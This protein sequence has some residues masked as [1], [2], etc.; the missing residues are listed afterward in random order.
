MLF[1]EERK[2]TGWNTSVL[3]TRYC[4]FWKNYTIAHKS[5]TLND[6]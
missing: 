4:F 6:V 5:E 1:S 3:L 2:K